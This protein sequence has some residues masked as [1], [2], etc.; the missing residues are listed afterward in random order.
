MIRQTFAIFIASVR[1]LPGRLAPSL[2][3]VF[4]IGG[5][6]AVLIGLAAIAEGFESALTSSGEADR[7]LVLRAGSTS[8]INGS[9]SIDQFEIMRDLPAVAAV[10]GD[11]LASMETFVTVNLP[12]ATSDATA[13]APMRGITADAFRVRPEIAV[14]SGRRLQPG[15]YEMLV[16][17]SAARQFGFAVDQVVTIRGVDWRVA[18]IFSAGGG[19]Y[20]A[21]LWVDQRLLAAAWNR[22]ASFSSM[23][24]RL[25]SADLFEE[26]Q[27]QIS[28][29]RRLTAHALRESDFYADQAKNT[30]ALIQGVGMVVVRIMMVGAMFAALNAMYAALSKRSSEIATLRA[31]GFAR[32]PIL[33]AVLLE[34]CLI[35]AIGALAGGGLIYLLLQDTQLA[36]TAATTATSTQIAFKFVVTPQMFATGVGLALSL[37]L[38]GGLV[39]AL[40]AVRQSIP[41]GLRRAG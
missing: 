5:V 14:I 12:Q 36:T 25:R 22:Q 11:K 23:L 10:E 33:L 21:E 24:V 39:P 8:E 38:L 15:K 26:F 17:R 30:T 7:A 9:M 28:A 2:I 6:V 19:A 27:Q 1:S 31:L 18:G 40:S 20:D 16:G 29:D 4:G 41:W 37:A 34:S 13:A 35:G 32:L 3:I